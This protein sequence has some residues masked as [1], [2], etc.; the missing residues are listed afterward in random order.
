MDAATAKK[1]FFW[2]RSCVPY[3]PYDG[4]FPWGDMALHCNLCD[5]DPQ[6]VKFCTPGAISVRQQV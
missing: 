1:S 5:G 6:C 4:I 3:C 2:K